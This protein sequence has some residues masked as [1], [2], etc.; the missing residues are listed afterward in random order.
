MKRIMILLLILAA[1]L[2][3]ACD[4]F[5]TCESPDKITSESFWRNASDAEAG[6]A[7]A[8]S[9]L[10]F[11]IDT[12]A[13]A[14]IKWPVE[15]YREDLILIGRDAS[16]YEDWV[17]LYDF[18]YTD[19]NTQLAEYWRI[20]YT[21]L[22]YCN[23]VISKVSEIDMDETYRNQIIN[24]AIF[25]RAYYHMKLLLNWEK[26]ILRDEYINSAE[27]LDKPLS[28]RVECWESIIQDLKQATNLPATQADNH[29]G[30][31]TSGAAWAYLGWT[32]LTRAYEQ[33]A[34]KEVD[35][36]AAI[37]A[38]DHVNGYSQ[39]SDFLS[40]FNGTN[41]NSKESIFELQFTLDRNN[42]ANYYTQL[43]Y[44]IASE[45][46]GGWDEIAPAEKLVAEFKKE[47]KISNSGGYDERLYATLIFDDEYFY[48]GN[49]IFSHNYDYYFTTGRRT[50][51]RKLLPDYANIDDE[52]S[53][54]NIPLMRY[55]NVLLMKAEALNELN[56]TSEAIPLINQIRE[57]H[58]NMPPMSGSSYDEVK[59]Q[60]EHERILEFP[61]ENFRFYDL[62]R[63]GTT[64]AALES[65]G[66]TNFDASKNDFFPI[67][68]TELNSNNSL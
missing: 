30:R 47:G 14:E 40:M 41:E 58:G 67:P 43:Q 56:R 20:N 15:A 54:Y 17:Q 52:N 35:L 64:K 25:L 9:Q 2:F 16:N 28:D 63:W 55:A 29:I 12:W 39:V 21:G 66:R 37:N 19:A 38:F 10:E 6:L 18:T 33:P 60:I 44:W 23:Q 51:F 1:T 36:S 4:D 26:I 50:V 48:T 65:V 62:R 59:V 13:F 22:N 34:M 57:I 68:R 61:L 32:Y 46:I 27:Q 24:E 31:A 8:Y 5:L 3:A 11:S 49:K 53:G 42:G 45:E 7:A